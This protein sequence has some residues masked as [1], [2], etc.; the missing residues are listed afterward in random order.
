LPRVSWCLKGGRFGHDPAVDVRNPDWY[1]ALLVPLTSEGIVPGRR[2]LIRQK[3]TVEV[4]DGSCSSCHSRVMPDGTL[5]NGPQTNFPLERENA[6]R[7]RMR[8]HNLNGLF[9]PDWNKFTLADGVME[10]NI[11]EYARIAE[12]VPPGVNMRTGVSVL[13][14]P[15]VADLIGVKDRKYLDL[16]G[17]SST[18]ISAI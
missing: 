3:G 13:T 7:F 4:D 15:K 5:R 8:E 12:A 11:E 6:W 9:F 1:D 10:K 18:G 17:R 14:P 2:Y 16:I